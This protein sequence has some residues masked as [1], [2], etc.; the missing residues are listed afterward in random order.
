MPS[1]RNGQP[2]TLLLLPGS[3]G[4]SAGR[5]FSQVVMTLSRGIAGVLKVPPQPGGV[6]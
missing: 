5:S 6:A 3:S 4:T 1:T 2:M